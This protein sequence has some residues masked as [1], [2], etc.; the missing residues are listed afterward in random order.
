MTST[1]LIADAMKPVSLGEIPSM[2]V[3]EEMAYYHISAT[4]V[5]GYVGPRPSTDLFQYHMREV[6]SSDL[7]GGNTDVQN[8]DNFIRALESQCCVVT[9]R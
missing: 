6:K 9:L 1:Q 5:W 2:L 4:P 7:K 3:S 8:V